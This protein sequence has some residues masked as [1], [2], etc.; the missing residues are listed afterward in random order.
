MQH[1][2]FFTQGNDQIKSAIDND[3]VYFQNF[4]TV[5]NQIKSSGKLVLMFS[6]LSKRTEPRFKLKPFGLLSL[7]TFKQSDQICV[8]WKI[9]E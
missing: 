1:F 4:E 6:E 9:V 2:Q 7:Q 8:T 5:K 3:L